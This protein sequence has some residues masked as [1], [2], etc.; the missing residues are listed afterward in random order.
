M[1]SCRINNL[2]TCASAGG[3]PSGFGRAIPRKLRSHISTCSRGG[4]VQDFLAT[5]PRPLHQR[6]LRSFFLMSRP[7]PPPAEEGSSHND[8][9][10]VS[11]GVQRLIH[12]Q[13]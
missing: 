7:P 8:T 3:G 11:R 1:T 12:R 6:R 10:C 9:P 13:L 2:D 5:P 4:V